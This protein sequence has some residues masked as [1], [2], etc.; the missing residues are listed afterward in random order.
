MRK[1]RGTAQHAPA[2]ATRRFT[3]QLERGDRLDPS[4]EINGAGQPGHSFS[5]VRV[6]PG[7]VSAYPSGWMPQPAQAARHQDAT[8]P[9]VIR[10]AAHLGVRTPSTQLPFAAQLQRAFAG[11]DLSRVQAHVGPKAT[12]SAQA[13]RADAYATGGHLVFAG[14]PSLRTVAHEL[15]HVVQQQQGVHLPD[16][17][18]GV[19]DVYERQADAVAGR[20]AAG[21]SATDLLKQSAGQVGA[22]HRQIA[23][24]A[25]SQP[26]A[27]SARIGTPAAPIQGEF[28]A[29]PKYDINGKIKKFSIS[30]RPA[31]RFK[32]L[33]GNHTTSYSAYRDVL[34][35]ATLGR[36][37]TDAYTNVSRLIDDLQHY[38]GYKDK[39]GT[40]PINKP[41]AK[42]VN[43]V[44][45][46]E[47]RALGK[48]YLEA[49]DSAP[50]SA[51]D[52]GPLKATTHGE[53]QSL[54]TLRELENKTDPFTNDDL[55]A[56]HTKM[57]ALFDE[58]AAKATG[59]QNLAEQQ[60]F[61]TMSQ[62][63]PRTYEELA[64][65]GQ[66]TDYSTK[67]SQFKPEGGAKRSLGKDIYNTLG[68]DVQPDVNTASGLNLNISG[69]TV[70]PFSTKSKMGHHTISHGL[71]EQAIKTQLTKDPNV[72][73]NLLGLIDTVR[74]NPIAQKTFS[75]KLASGPKKNFKLAR[76][77]LKKARKAIDLAPTQMPPLRDVEQAVES[78]LLHHNV[79]PL[80]AIDLGSLANNNNEQ[81]ALEMM[82]NFEAT[83]EP[84][85]SSRLKETRPQLTRNTS[86]VS[87]I[88]NNLQDKKPISAILEAESGM[89]EEYPG[90]G[91]NPNQTDKTKAVAAIQ[92]S[93]HNLL[94]LAAPQAY[95]QL[96]LNNKSD[97]QT[98]LQQ[99]V[100]TTESDEIINQMTVPLRDVFTATG[101]RRPYKEELAKPKNKN[102]KIKK[103]D[104][105]DDDYG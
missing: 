83:G 105:D 100:G 74:D 4:A 89:E 59:D 25:L 40:L 90:L 6:G 10:Q 97:V 22:P 30:G 79:S 60:H 55:N 21:Q 80:S 71:V 98:Y 81:T 32:G 23:W 41:N 70:G 104:S 66:V 17:I 101:K 91:S 11:Y 58:E 96:Q 99:Q 84:T 48:Y 8:G 42:D 5:K 36:S 44:Q 72:K 68:V 92:D 52:L 19:G 18:G 87:H 39:L 75:K 102:K 46:E 29:N 9:E 16:G 38:P 69:R 7:V 103:N 86:F 54:R 53:A 64:K 50:L 82:R 34:E 2:P 94:K 26:L 15:T 93:F 24:Q 27:G 63:F 76:K 47:L 20:V 45:E 12:A 1:P 14:R 28:T 62:A 31:G 78:I 51:A 57:K 56:A 88:Q 35:S 77:E 43:D 61:M 85:V 65:K 73:D 3:L 95:N 67:L 49:R 37:T 33:Q 13:M